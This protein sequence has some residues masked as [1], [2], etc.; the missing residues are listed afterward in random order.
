MTLTSR[1]RRRARVALGVV[2]AHD[3]VPDALDAPALRL[4]RRANRTSGGVQA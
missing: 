1:T 3:R 2:A 4:G